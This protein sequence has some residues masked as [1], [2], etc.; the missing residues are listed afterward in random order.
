MYCEKNSLCCRTTENDVY[1]IAMGLAKRYKLDE[2]EVYMT[3][4]EFLFESG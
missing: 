4:L 1:E 3:H 2:W